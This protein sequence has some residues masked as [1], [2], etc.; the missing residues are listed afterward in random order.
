MLGW[1][2]QPV[3]GLPWTWE[4]CLYL[5]I[6]PAIGETGKGLPQALA[7]LRIGGK[8]ESIFSLFSINAISHYFQRA[9]WQG[10]ALPVLCPVWVQICCKPGRCSP[11]SGRT[12]CQGEEAL[13]GIPV[14][15][16]GCRSCVGAE[17]GSGSTSPVNKPW[18]AEQG[19]S[20]R[21]SPS[22]LRRWL[23]AKSPA[24]QHRFP[25]CRTRSKSYPGV[26]LLLGSCFLYYVAAHEGAV[27]QG[28][29]TSSL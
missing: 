2:V 20:P 9:C 8:N 27:S 5:W 26:F 18:E 10:L 3:P 28:F 21:I 12:S 15:L 6:Q 11:S 25:R 23:P 13:L 1:D 22:R 16:H 4:S 19:L 17:P 24:P 7:P 29:Q 14:S